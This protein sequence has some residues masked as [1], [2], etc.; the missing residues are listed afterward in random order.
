MDMTDGRRLT[1]VSSLSKGQA[2]TGW[3]EASTLNHVFS[4]DC[5]AW[6]K[7]PR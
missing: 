6:P 2:D 3:P 4:T 5:P 7:A 1:L